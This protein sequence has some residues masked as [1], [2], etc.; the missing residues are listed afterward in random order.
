[1]CPLEHWNSLLLFLFLEYKNIFHRESEWCCINNFQSWEK[2]TIKDFA[3][4]QSKTVS[5]A[6]P[7]MPVTQKQEQVTRSETENTNWYIYQ[8]FPCLSFKP[9][10]AVKLSKNC[11]TNQRLWDSK[12]RHLDFSLN[13]HWE[14]YI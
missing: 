4:V 11:S 10:L 8:Q 5:E 9:F 2:N 7:S 3:S 6:F 1:M 13:L 14:C 12:S